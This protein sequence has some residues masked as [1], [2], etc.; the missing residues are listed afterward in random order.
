MDDDTL[1]IRYYLAVFWRHRRLIIAVTLAAVLVAVPVT[2]MSR[3]VYE[4]VAVLSVPQATL[5]VGTPGGSTAAGPSISEVLNPQLP[6]Q[7]LAQFAMLDGL[8]EAV[9]RSASST[10]TGVHEKFAATIPRDGGNM[11]ELGVRGSNPERVA[12]IANLWAAVVSEKGSG[13]FQAE[14]RQ[15][16]AFFDREL[17]SARSRLNGSEEALRRFN[18]RSRV[19]EL[20]ARVQALTSQIAAYQSDLL[21]LSV[22]LEQ[23]EAR[24]NA[25]RS[26]LR[27]QPRVY[28]LTKA[29]TTDPDAV[30]AARQDL[31]TLSHLSL[32]TQELNTVYVSLDQQAANTAVQVTEL[33]A[34]RAA[35]AKTMRD[36]QAQLSS[37]RNELAALQYQA[38][39]LTR[40]ADDTRLLYAGFLKRQQETALASAAT[41]A[42]PVVVALEASVP[43][44]PLPRHR[45]STL[46]I[47]GILGFFLALAAALVIEYLH[48]P[49]ARAPLPRSG[50][51]QPLPAATGIGSNGD[52]GS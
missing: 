11:V 26:Q 40:T 42:S 24:W 36:M 9:T 22:R 45:G 52:P 23:T 29:V 50:L 2:L 33:R 4:A 44:Q 16:F 51:P 5:Q 13:L 18:A 32:R 15:S 39:Q 34:E 27:E 49:S 10:T 46:A 21:D 8:L 14:A 37:M 35:T 25:I 48:V 12:K 41:H 38:T 3:P 19:G 20:Q 7:S 47:F 30:A 17:Q 31:A 1:D 43:A 6:A 28:T